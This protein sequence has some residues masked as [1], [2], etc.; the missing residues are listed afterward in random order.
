MPIHKLLFLIYLLSSFY[1]LNASTETLTENAAIEIPEISAIE[2]EP[3]QIEISADMRA[4]LATEEIQAVENIR[5]FYLKDLFKFTRFE[6][7]LPSSAF[8]GTQFVS[9]SDLLVSPNSNNLIKEGGASLSDEQLKSLREEAL[10]IVPSQEYPGQNNIWKINGWFI[11][12]T[13]EIKL[14]VRKMG[15]AANSEIT[16]MLPDTFIGHSKDWFHPSFNRAF[17]NI[18]KG[19]G[20]TLVN[21]I[22]ARKMTKAYNSS[23]VAA[24]LEKLFLKANPNANPLDLPS[25]QEKYLPI[26]NKISNDVLLSWQQSLQSKF[27]DEFVAQARKES[28]DPADQSLRVEQL[29][30]EKLFE[31][32][33]Q[34]LN[35]SGELKA[36]RADLAQLLIER[37]KANLIVEGAFFQINADFAELYKQAESF[38]SQKHPHLSKISNFFQFAVARVYR[39]IYLRRRFAAYMPLIEKLG[40][41]GF[42][43]DAVQV[44]K[45]LKFLEMDSASHDKKIRNKTEATGDVRS[46]RIIWDPKDW[47]VQKIDDPREPYTASKVIYS[48]AKSNWIGWRAWL[49]FLRAKNY[50][51]NINYWA[52]KKELWNG[53]F[54]L[55]ALVEEKAFYGQKTLNPETG[56]L[57]DLKSSKRETLRSA[58]AAISQEAKDYN[59]AD[60]QHDLLSESTYAKLAKLWRGT[61]KVALGLGR[62]A[63][64]F[65][66]VVVSAAACLSSVPLAIVGSGLQTAFNLSVYDF[67]LPRDK[68][69][70]EVK[71]RISP[72][73]QGIVTLGGGVLD[74]A[75][76]VLRVPAHVIAFGVIDAS[77][78]AVQA[79]RLRDWAAR[80]IFFNKK[81]MKVPGRDSKVIKRIQGPG[82]SS[83]YY[84]QI[85]EDL[86]LLVLQANLEK[87][88][89][90]LFSQFTMAQAQKPL[91]ALQRSLK[92]LFGAFF[93]NLGEGNLEKAAYAKEIISSVK[94]AEKYVKENVSARR[95]TIAKLIGV[96]SKELDRVRLSQASLN[97]LLP[98]ALAL[99]KKFYAEKLSKNFLNDKVKAQF[100]ANFT[101]NENDFI[102]L[103]QALLKNSFG[104]NILSSLEA[105]DSTFTLQSKDVGLGE[106]VSNLMTGI[107]PDNSMPVD[108]SVKKFPS[109]A[110]YV[111]PTEVSVD[112]QFTS[113][114]QQSCASYLLDIIEGAR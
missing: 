16:V 35:N 103:T 59:P 107:D 99:T 49:F 70:F 78:L 112:A 6:P 47:I 93:T 20:L 60:H 12:G 43:D 77:T 40:Q 23:E 33:Y 66:N 104:P 10:I 37:H 108:S 31:L 97:S 17:R 80:F 41:A 53:K 52:F 106:L 102:G 56:E 45:L 85:K 13:K 34:A 65:C 89:L 64:A 105:T 91:N 92:K 24:E 82:L 21:A 63:G 111:D 25:L 27:R 38:V 79:V 73:V 76:S 69:T 74:F 36:L 2:T 54:G 50:F 29:L 39:K 22:G 61:R 48:S 68:N 1:N 18:F 44:A 113:L 110:K 86:A 67:D 95:E 75:A 90:E 88:E 15:E 46:G 28:T 30:S 4:E 96:H 42:H 5:K 51:F 55:R 14:I 101:L 9:L 58:W 98:R 87:Q 71:N 26:V 8:A 83:E 72:L 109:V 114:A 84:F 3:V 7:E 62:P 94:D 57:I 11:L 81:S 32:Y 19:I 100:W